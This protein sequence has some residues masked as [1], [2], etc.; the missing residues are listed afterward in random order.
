MVIVIRITRAV[1]SFAVLIMSLIQTRMD[2]FECH[3]DGERV[4]KIL[5]LT[6]AV[7]I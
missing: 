2:S 1:L 4:A 5:L 7:A 6:G 3:N